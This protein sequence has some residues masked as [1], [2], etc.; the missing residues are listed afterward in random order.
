[1]N[2]HSHYLSGKQWCTGK[3]GRHYNHYEADGSVQFSLFKL[4]YKYYYKKSLGFFGENILLKIKETKTIN[5]EVYCVC[6]NTINFA[7]L[8]KPEDLYLND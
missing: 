1:M 6:L 3:T 2:I 5:G 8:I 4:G 7:Y